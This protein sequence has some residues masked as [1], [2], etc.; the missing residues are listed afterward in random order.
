MQNNYFL[1]FNYLI[2]YNASD[3]RPGKKFMMDG[4]PYECIS[5]SQK[6]M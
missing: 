6:V 4:Q 1:T 3:L 5:Y 2:M